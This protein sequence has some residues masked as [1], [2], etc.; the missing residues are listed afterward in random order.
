MKLQSAW[1]WLTAWLAIGIICICVDPAIRP[2]LKQWGQARPIHIVAM[3]WQEIG[4]LTG[5]VLFLAAGGVL[6]W[7]DRGRTLVRFGI[8]LAGAGMAAQIFKHV[9]GRVRPNDLNDASMFVGPNNPFT[10]YPLPLDSMPS[11]HTTAAFAMAVMLTWR[12]P[13]LRWLWYLLAVGVAVSRVMLDWHFPSDVLIGA[14]LGVMVSR[15]MIKCWSRGTKDRA[16]QV[17]D[18]RESLSGDRS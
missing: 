9:I 15:G 8:G 10:R 2:F 17:S 7:R 13:R 5:I 4:A 6:A 11:G 14:W 1:F 18:R 16:A 12:W 3:Y